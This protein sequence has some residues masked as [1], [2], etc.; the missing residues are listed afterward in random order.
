M[1]IFNYINKLNMKNQLTILGGVLIIVSMF[2]P[3]VSLFGHGYKILDNS[4]GVGIFW[5]SCGILIAISGFL[6]KRKLNILGLILAIVTTAIA[7]KYY[8]DA[9]GGAG[10]GIL[11]MLG[12]GI[13]S[14]IGTYKSV[15]GK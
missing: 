9:M 6:E 3:M 4:K 2:L 12:G 7:G 11:V 14:I 13:L 8:N 10:L 15:K 5:I 1:I